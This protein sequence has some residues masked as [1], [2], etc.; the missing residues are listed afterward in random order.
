[1]GAG[2]KIHPLN[3]ISKMSVR[4]DSTP[5]IFAALIVESFSMLLEINHVILKLKV[6]NSVQ[7]ENIGPTFIVLCLESERQNI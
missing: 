2:V 6:R 1:M 7:N 4:C 3:I 5:I